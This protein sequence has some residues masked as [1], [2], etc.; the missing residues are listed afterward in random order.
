MIESY[1]LKNS[2]WRTRAVFKANGL[3]TEEI[4]PF[5]NAGVRILPY[6]SFSSGLNTIECYIRKQDFPNIE[7]A[8]HFSKSKIL[9]FTDQISIITNDKVDILSFLSTCPMKVSRG[10]IFEILLP[11]ESYVDKNQFNIKSD[12]LT[13]FKQVI[14]N[15]NYLEA[16][17]QFREGLCSISNNS[18]ILFYFSALE[19]VAEFE[20]TEKIIYQCPKCGNNDDRGIATSRYIQSELAKYGI[21]KKQYSKIRKLRSKIAHGSGQRDICF[22]N[23]VNATLP[24]LESST[25]SILSNRCGFEIKSVNKIHISDDFLILKGKKICSLNPYHL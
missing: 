24:S 7:D 16:I 25:L 22:I 12:D 9:E 2:D 3:F 19:R 6:N 10:D 15:S 20:A 8:F 21:N 1:C 23:E 4:Y 11:Q 17:R 18:K 5:V 13:Y 14:Q